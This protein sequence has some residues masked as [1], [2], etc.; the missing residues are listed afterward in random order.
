MTFILLNL[1]EMMKNIETEKLISSQ[2]QTRRLIKV[3]RPCK[4]H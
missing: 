1:Y 3:L 2:Q 4:A